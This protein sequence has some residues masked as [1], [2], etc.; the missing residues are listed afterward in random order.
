MAP[1]MEPTGM[2][3]WICSCVR[4]VLQMRTSVTAPLNKGSHEYRL[5]PM[6]FD[7]E[8]VET[9]KDEDVPDAAS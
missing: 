8:A 7:V 3:A 2:L 4:A 1:E 5:L 6:K 9:P